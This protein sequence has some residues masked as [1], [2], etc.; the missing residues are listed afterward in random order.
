VSQTV[1]VYSGLIASRT[2]ECVQAKVASPLATFRLARAAFLRCCVEG[3][4][5]LDPNGLAQ[6]RV[7]HQYAVHTGLRIMQTDRARCG[8]RPA[9][10]IAPDARVPAQGN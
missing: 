5:V 2:V 7:D 6:I 9:V 10:V 1:A 3:S 4:D 8:C